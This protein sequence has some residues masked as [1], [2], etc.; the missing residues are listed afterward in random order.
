MTLPTTVRIP[1][2]PTLLNGVDNTSFA[3]DITDLE[4]MAAGDLSEFVNE[5][6]VSEDAGVFNPAGFV[7]VVK[8]GNINPR[9]LAKDAAQFLGD[10]PAGAELAAR[11]IAGEAGAAGGATAGLFGGI[12]AAGAKFAMSLNSAGS[13]PPQG[14]DAN[15]PVSLR[16]PWVDIME[17]M[18]HTVKNT[19]VLRGIFHNVLWTQLFGRKQGV[20][21]FWIEVTDPNDPLFVTAPARTK[22]MKIS[23]LGGVSGAD[24]SSY[25]DHDVDVLHF[26][27]STGSRLKGTSYAI[28]AL[29]LPY[30]RVPESARGGSDVLR[31]SV[32]KFFETAVGSRGENRDRVDLALT[33]EV[34][35]K[36]MI[37]AEILEDWYMQYWKKDQDRKLARDIIIAFAQA[38]FPTVSFDNHDGMQI[39]GSGDQTD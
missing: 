21:H 26:I 12:A 33:S 20:N 2:A 15:S 1:F 19:S 30:D 9:S 27:Q 34:L 37:S 8:P 4:Q 16:P 11:A 36:M 5:G 14:P 38:I 17:K 24:L 35:R 22:A 18:I 23:Y 29:A 13:A 3:G 39:V 31:D 25:Q 7:N 28:D 32:F 6:P 10:I